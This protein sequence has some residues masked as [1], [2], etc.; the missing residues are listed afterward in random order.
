VLSVVV[1]KTT[2]TLA[3]GLFL[4]LGI[5][6]AAMA[7]LPGSTL[8]QAMMWLLALEVL[9]LAGFVVAQV[10]GVFGWGQRWLGRVG[11]RLSRHTET[12]ARVDRGLLSFYGE[13]PRRLTLSIAFH[14]LAWLLG[15]AEVYLVLRFL[16]VAVSLTTATIIEA[17]GTAVRFATFLVPASIGAQEGG[18]VA[19]FV[20]LGLPPPAGVALGLTRRV[21]EILWIAV[22]FVIFAAMRHD[23]R[24]EVGSAG[25]AR[26]A[27][28]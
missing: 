22:G 28:Q 9:A 6:V 17:C 5:V 11:I 27:G 19:T 2:I 12:G 8:L 21:R 14:L 10:R 16:G 4:L 15:V 25:S 1:A 24:P 3:Q 26:S 20:A 18:Y 13:E 7:G 23:A